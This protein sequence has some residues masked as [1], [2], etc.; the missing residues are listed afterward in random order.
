M[1]T[2]FMELDFVGANFNMTVTPAM[3]VK[4]GEIFDDISAELGRTVT[5]FNVAIVST[6]LITNV[7]GDES[8]LGTGNGGIMQFFLVGRDVA[9]TPSLLALPYTIHDNSSITGHFVSSGHTAFPAATPM[10]I[11]V[12][13]NLGKDNKLLH[14]YKL[15][16]TDANI[17]IKQ[18]LRMCPSGSGGS[19][20]DTS[21]DLSIPA[22]TT[23]W[24]FGALSTGYPFFNA[25]ARVTGD[26]AENQSK[27]EIKKMNA[28]VTINGNVHDY[29]D[30]FRD[31][32]VRQ[33]RRTSAYGIFGQGI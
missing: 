23:R 22:L 11:S 31:A 2:S 12:T 10:D 5:P 27:L 1:A 18:E 15:K 3:S 28:P 20:G 6:S 17:N 25:S 29:G 30:I 19:F 8:R 7:R 33:I 9:T 24:P 14:D 4:I 21:V 13:Q 32:T 26:L 16:A